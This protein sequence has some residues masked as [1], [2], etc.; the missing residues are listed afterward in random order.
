MIATNKRSKLQL[1][2]LRM[3]S[4]IPGVKIDLG[5]STSSN[6]QLLK[7]PSA[8]TPDEISMTLPIRRK[9]I[10]KMTPEEIARDEQDREARYALIRKLREFGIVLPNDQLLN[11]MNFDGPPM[12]V[13]KTT[14]TVFV[15][16]GHSMTSSSRTGEKMAKFDL[17][18]LVDGTTIS[19]TR[20][21]LDNFF[22][23]VH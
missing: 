3:L 10:M 9:E 11:I 2:M 23:K 8:L 13:P 21:Q 20:E 22:Q 18:N 7:I 17:E 15:L 6:D 16:S 12:Y 5:M 4:Y 1:F 19:L 14:N